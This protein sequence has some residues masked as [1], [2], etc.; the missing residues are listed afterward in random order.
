MRGRKT[1]FRSKSMHFSISLSR[2]LRYSSIYL[3]LSFVHCL[4]VVLMKQYILAIKMSILVP[5]KTSM[6]SSGKHLAITSTVVN[7]SIQLPTIYSYNYVSSLH[8]NTSLHCLFI[9]P[10]TKST[11][12][13]KSCKYLFSIS[14]TFDMI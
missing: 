5:F 14:K 7:D 2:V 12:S 8:F 13:L 9:S 3:G 1:L 6:T 4:N 11:I 10:M